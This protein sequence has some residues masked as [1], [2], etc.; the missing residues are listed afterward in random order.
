VEVSIEKREK[1]TAYEYSY[2]MEKLAEKMTGK[3]SLRFG[4][5]FMP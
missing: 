4:T 1:G 3:A 2:D 5:R